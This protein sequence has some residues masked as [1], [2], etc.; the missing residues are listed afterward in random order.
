MK[1]KLMI[2]SLLVLGLS[3]CAQ[4]AC[5][6]YSNNNSKAVESA[7]VDVEKVESHI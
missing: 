6:T 4:Y 5:P 3:S 7:K 2:F 1:V